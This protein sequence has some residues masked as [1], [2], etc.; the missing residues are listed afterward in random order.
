MSPCILN[1]EYFGFNS[2]ATPCCPLAGRPLDY[3]LYSGDEDEADD[4][5]SAEL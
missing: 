4:L 2:G 3:F 1:I 5:L